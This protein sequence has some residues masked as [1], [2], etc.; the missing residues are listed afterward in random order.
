MKH[1][2]WH[3]AQKEMQPIFKKF[4]TYKIIGPADEGVNVIICEGATG[5]FCLE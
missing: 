4:R 5:M 2:P 1:T 3:K